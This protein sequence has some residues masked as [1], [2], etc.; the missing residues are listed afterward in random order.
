VGPFGEK[1]L[2]SVFQGAQSFGL[3]ISGNGFENPG[4]PAIG[5]HDVLGGTAGSLAE[6][7]GDVAS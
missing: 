5:S 2:L 6:P 7:P 3:G 1:D 4:V